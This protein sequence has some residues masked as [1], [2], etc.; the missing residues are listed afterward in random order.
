M[1]NQ[2]DTASAVAAY[3]NPQINEPAQAAKAS[4]MVAVDSNPDLEAD[5]RRASAATGVPLGAARAYPDDVKRQAMIEAQDFDQLSKTYPTTTRFLTEPENARISHDD[6][7]NLSQTESTIGPIVGPKPDFFSVVSGL[8][9]SLPQGAELA[10]QGMR[11]QLADLFGFDAVRRDAQERYSRADLERADATPDIKGATASAVY[12]G[13]SS[14]LR[15]APGLVASLA[16]RSTA[17]MLATMGVQTESEAYGKYRNRGATASEA[18]VGGALEGTIEVGTEMLPMGYLVQ[19]LGRVNA[20]HFLTGL[21]AREIPGE[22]LATLT[23]D[24]VDTA[25]ANPDKTWGEYLAERPGAAYQTLVATITQASIMGGLNAAAGRVTGRQQQ[26]EHANTIGDALQQLNSL[27]EASKVRERD[28]STAQQFFQSLTGEGRDS[29][30]IT[31]EALQ[32]SGLAEQIIQAVPGVAEQL[33]TAIDSGTDIRL[34]IADLMTNLAGPELAQSIIPH[35]ADEPGG[36]TQTTAGE[37]LKSGAAQELQAE[38]QRV[39][40][41]KQQDDAFNTSRN[42]VTQ[43]IATQL[44][45]ATRFTPEVNQAYATMAGNF[46]A[47]QAAKL[48]ITPEE[49]AAR[50][51]LQVRAEALPGARTLDQQQQP[52]FTVSGNLPARGLA[53][54][55]LSSTGV[56]YVGEPNSLHFIVAGQAPESDRNFVSTG[57]VTPDGQ[58]LDRDQAL[59]WVNKNEKK[60]RQSANMDEGLDSA[61]YREQVPESMRKGAVQQEARGSMSISDDIT[62][63]PTIIT[64]LQKANLTTFS[65]ELGHFFLEVQAHIAAQHDAPAGIVDDMAKTLAWFGVPDL[66]TWDAMDLEQKRPYH[67]QFARGFEAYL[68]EGKAPTPELQ[69]L[70]ARFR[71]WMVSVY[72]SLT[73]LDVTLTDEVRGVF[74]RMVASTESITEAEADQGLEG[75]F[76]TKPGF[77]QDDEWRAY[78]QLSVDA[79]QD[80]ITQ[81][82]QRSLRD[83]KWLTNAKARI[84]RDMQREAADRRKTVRAEVEKEVMAEPVNQAR[85]FLRRGLNPDGTPAP[86]AHKLAIASLTEMYGG[87]GDRF[88]LLDWS[89]LGYGKYGALAETGLSPDALAEIVGYPSG[90]AMVRDLLT[91][92]PARAVI[93]DQTNQRMLERYGDLKDQASIDAAINLALAGEARARFLA[94]ELNALN[95][96]TGRA[97]VLAAAAKSYAAAA[98]A[99]LKVSELRPDVFLAAARRSAKASQAALAKDD[100]QLAAVEKQNHLINT[101]A[102]RAALDAKTE[103]AKTLQGFNKIARGNNEK[104]SKTR[105]LDMVMATRAILAEFGIGTRGKAASEYLK[106]VEAYDPEM[107]AVLVDRIQQVTAGAL[108]FRELTIEQVRGL[109]DEIDSLMYLA[110]RSRQMEVDGDLMDRQDVQDQLRARLEEIGIPEIIPGEGKAITEGEVMITRLQNL[111]AILRRMEAWTDATDGAGTK[112]GPFRRYIFSQVKD[113]ADN[114]RAD[115]AKFLRQYRELLDPIAKTLTATKIAAPEIGYTFGFDKGGAG[116][117]ELLHA[118]LHTGNESNMKKMLLGRNWASLKE[119]GTLDTT[120]WDTFINRMISEGRLTKADFDFAQGVW[121]LMESMKPMAQKTHRE[122]FGRY[123][124]EIT[125]TPFENQ[126]GKYAG[127]Y[128][129]AMADS[130][131]VADARTR[132][133]AESE[134]ATLQ[135]SFP[136]TSRGFTKS[137]VEYNRPLMLDLRTISQHIDKVLLFSH[138]EQPVREVRKVLTSSQIAVPM[139]RI[140]PTVFDSLINPWLHRASRQQVESPV[141]GSWGNMRIFAVLRARAGMAAMFANV[142][143]TLQQITGFSVAALKVSPR[144]LGPAAID[145]LRNP[146]NATEAIAAVS[147]YMRL[148]MENE[149]QALSGIINDILI[150]PSTI[151]KAQAWTSKHAYFLQSAVDNV[152][153]PIIWQGAYNQALETAPAGMSQAALELYARR[154]ADSSVR[155]TQGSTLPEDV[156]RIETGNAFVRMFTQ[157]YG[158][159]NMVANLNATELVKISE[160]V[161]LRKGAG[162]GLYVLFFGLLAPAWVAQA[163]ALAFRGGPDDEDKDGAYWDDWMAQTFGWGTLR[164]LTAMVPVAGQVINALANTANGKPYDDKIS[165][166]PAISMLESSVSAP[167]SVYKAVTGQGGEGKAVR[168]VSTLVSIATGIPALGL[169]KPLIYGTDVASGRT[170][171]LGPADAARGVITGTSSPESKQR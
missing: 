79:T 113:A 78:Q 71:A 82:E 128:V 165:T 169:A 153:S 151:E 117:A 155:E 53:P 131:I 171:P 48:G 99:R 118:I 89:K 56:L 36:F 114:Y 50:Y 134:N 7:E 167:R 110:K 147:P 69:P 136:Q 141:D 58:Y 68:F 37:Y 145:F 59:D 154:L 13:A 39:T 76:H 11:M 108:P 157:F 142:S 92:P 6:I 86:V 32:A 166:S 168:D 70:F 106:S 49:M 111:R 140:D 146:Q 150:N 51:P 97:P 52:E 57:F 96:A 133:L 137:R 87:E 3:L 55:N 115:K 98:I 103:M 61:D 132:A 94:T 101:Y 22:Q 162:R 120:R 161:G 10:R 107:S 27:A 33:R 152:M 143:N 80:A 75:M 42:A 84:L 83:M 148:R 121:N 156:S 160:E 12:G 100:L 95:K 8:A 149:V 124:D 40:E 77:M 126:F 109:K 38:V 144:Y 19:N 85:Q 66:A 1:E 163:I 5:L 102:A 31:P 46:Y 91:A 30:W 18:F 158:Y 45:Q 130:R 170:R 63:N 67:E 81:L 164:N 125:A 60:I 62:Q 112:M 73:A 105:D 65:H 135:A 104:V 123:F 122:V 17:P 72:K 139:N 24:A 127:G 90:D 2:V 41:Q 35:L 88:A 47:V 138:L 14:T 26:A 129:P 116:K 20:G 93:E 74:D 23:Q 4:M 34:P 28:A 159:F 9:K 54:A 29:V 119:D 64:L 43:Q 44:D 16:T 25:I 21:L 15:M